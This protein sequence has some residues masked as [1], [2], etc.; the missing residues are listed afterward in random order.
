MSSGNGCQ[1]KNLPQRY[2]ISNLTNDMY[3]A[4][5]PALT[6]IFFQ[7]KYFYENKQEVAK[8]L[9]ISFILNFSLINYL[10]V[11]KAQLFPIIYIKHFFQLLEYINTFKILNGVQCIM[12]PLKIKK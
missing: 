5:D 1:D 4:T 10:F 9:Q 3:E 11:K 2:N 6:R 12:V 7:T 8:D